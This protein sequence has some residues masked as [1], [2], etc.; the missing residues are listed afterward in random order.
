MAIAERDGLYLGERPILNCTSPRVPLSGSTGYFEPK[1]SR[2]TKYLTSPFTNKESQDSKARNGTPRELT[3]FE[4]VTILSSS[5][6]LQN[7]G[8]KPALRIASK[9]L[10]QGEE[11][12][13]ARQS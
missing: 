5:L 4:T 9:S 6:N 12:M 11:K 10:N 8:L 1:L 2:S 3:F 13:L 7:P